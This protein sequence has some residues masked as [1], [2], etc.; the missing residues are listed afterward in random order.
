[1]KNKYLVT[2]IVPVI[3]FEFD[4][5][6]PNNKK[7]GTIKKFIIMSLKELSNNS[8]NKEIDDVRIIDRDTYKELD[9]N[10]FVKDAGIKNG[11]KLIII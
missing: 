10:L 2:I 1:M 8:Y 6:I 4:I 5:Y 3:E 7:V 11:S 9:N